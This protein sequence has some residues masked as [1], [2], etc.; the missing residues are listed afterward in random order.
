M[1]PSMETNE[2]VIAAIKQFLAIMC[3]ADATLTIWLKVLGAFM[4]A[5]CN[6]TQQLLKSLD[7]PNI[8]VL[9]KA[10]DNFIDSAA[11]MFSKKAVG[12]SSTKVLLSLASGV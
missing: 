5:A 6:F 4:L 10:V 1:S 12:L 9:S 8:P 7:H 2:F 11:L 3:P